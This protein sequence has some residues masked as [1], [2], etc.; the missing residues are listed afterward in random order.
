M[1]AN[2]QAL[3]RASHEPRTPLNAILGFGQLLA[4]DELDES[5]RHNVDQIMAGGRHL[6]ALIED[7]LDVSG[8]DAAGLD[9]GPVDTGAQI[10]GAV[11]LC[12]PLAVGESLTVTVDAGTEPLGRSPT[13]A[14][15]SRCC[16]T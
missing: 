8:L 15:S 10:E 13:P 6:L 3:S 7:L 14:G 4:L 12:Q 2:S 9:L 16:S 1:F 11:A 5:Q